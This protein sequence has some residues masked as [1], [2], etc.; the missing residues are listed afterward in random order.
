MYPAAIPLRDDLTTA[1]A[2]SWA[3][4]GQPGDFWTGAERVDMV[5]SAREALS[6]P[7][8][9][10]RKT[11]L[12]PFAVAAEKQAGHD[13]QSRLPPV[14]IDM[15][16]RIRTDSGRLTREW[17]DSVIASGITPQQYVEVVGVV[18][19]SVIID[20]L[21]QSLGLDVPDLP[22]AESGAPRGQDNPDA[23]DRGAWV[24]VMDAEEDLAATGLPNAPNIARAMG[25]V[26][27][28]VALF[29]QTFRPHYALSDIPL[30]ISQAQAEFVA[31]R[32]SAINECFY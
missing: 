10:T 19:T 7:L 15:I 4:I 21:H 9:A 16:H 26:P 31:S 30:E 12:S 20:T 14:I 17:F 2:A 6:C 22:T 29:F 23:V 32:V 5:A 25:L 13:T 27:G 3:Q 8:C 11:A 18:N 1:H 28:S 24:P